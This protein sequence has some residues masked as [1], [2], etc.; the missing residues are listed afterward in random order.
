[1][2][3]GEAGRRAGEAAKEG[4][5]RAAIRY[6]C[7][8]VLLRLDEADLLH[9]DRAATNSEYLFKAPGNLQEGLQPLL[10]QFSAVWYGNQPATQSD[11]QDYTTRAE[12][13]ELQ[14]RPK[15]GGRQAA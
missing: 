4:D 1:M 5:Y 2:G 8:A 11:W 13:L 9:F 10:A 12:A 15:S 6:R 3:A 7:L 14:I